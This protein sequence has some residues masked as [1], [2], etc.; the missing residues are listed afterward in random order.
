[1][2]KFTFTFTHQMEWSDRSAHSPSHTGQI[3]CAATLPDGDRVELS[4]EAV[5]IARWNQEHMSAQNYVQLHENVRVRDSFGGGDD[6]SRRHGRSWSK[7][8]ILAP[9]GSK[10][11]FSRNCPGCGET[12]GEQELPGEHSWEQ[13]EPL[14]HDA[15]RREQDAMDA[16]D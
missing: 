8:E 11:L 5:E 2:A 16:A 12:A 3:P 4:V 10:F 7:L 14:W 13:A 9:A 6:G 15:C 1:M